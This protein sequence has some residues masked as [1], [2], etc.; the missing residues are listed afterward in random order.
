VASSAATSCIPWRPRGVTPRKANDLLHEYIED[1]RRGTAVFHDHFVGSP[2]GGVAVLEVREQ[3]AFSLLDDPGPL[4]GW[5]VSV[6]PLMFA[7]AATG[8][9]ELIDFT[10][11]RYAETSLAALQEREE[12]DPR[13]WWREANG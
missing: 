3:G 10:L 1:R 11:R 6:H 12:D 7:L 8:F 4:E 5:T 13:Y 2:S 9:S